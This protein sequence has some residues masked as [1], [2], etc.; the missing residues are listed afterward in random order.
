MARLRVRPE[1]LGA[2]REQAAYYRRKKLWETAERFEDKAIATC[3][4]LA[5]DPWV[6]LRRQSR[7]HG[8]EVRIATIEGFQRHIV[9]YFQDGD[10]VVVVDFTRATRDLARRLGLS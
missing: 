5:Q 10:D 4:R 2:L 6:G 9:V 3:E 7:R 1:A 8:R